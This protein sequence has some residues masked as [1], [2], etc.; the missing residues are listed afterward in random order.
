MS[1]FF[2]RATATLGG[3]VLL[4]GSAF[5]NTTNCTPDPSIGLTCT[6]QVPEPGSLALVALAIAGVAVVSKFGKK[7]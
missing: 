2:T 5:A 7:K 4:A 3:W 6:N 1:Q